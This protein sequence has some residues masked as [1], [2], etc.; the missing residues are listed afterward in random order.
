MCFLLERPNEPTPEFEHLLYRLL[1]KLLEGDPS[2]GELFLKL[3]FH[4]SYF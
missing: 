4:R 2:I 1:G 3:N